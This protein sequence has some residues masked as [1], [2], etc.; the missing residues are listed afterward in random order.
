M[1]TSFIVYIASISTGIH[2]FLGVGAGILAIM[3]IAL[4]V[5]RC[6]KDCDYENKPKY[7]KYAWLSLLAM[8]LFGGACAIVPMEADVYKIAGVTEQ[9][10]AAINAIG[11]IIQLKNKGGE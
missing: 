9:E 11:S 7:Y 6:D 8:V 5:A 4:F 1:S 2:A 10:K 3:A